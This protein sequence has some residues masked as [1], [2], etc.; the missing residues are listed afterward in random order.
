MASVATVAIV[1]STLK[2]ANAVNVVGKPSY[3]RFLPGTTNWNIEFSYLVLLVA[4][5]K[6]RRYEP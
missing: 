6:R 4:T 5:A 1:L 2:V 3:H